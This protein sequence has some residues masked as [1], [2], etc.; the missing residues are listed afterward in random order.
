[1]SQLTRVHRRILCFFQMNLNYPGT[2]KVVILKS[3]LRI[4]SLSLH[5]F[6]FIAPHFMIL[7]TSLDYW[8]PHYVIFSIF[9]LLK[10][11]ST[12]PLKLINSNCLVQQ[13]GN[14]DFT[15]TVMD[16]HAEDLGYS[17]VEASSPT[18]PISSPYLWDSTCLPRGTI[19]FSLSKCGK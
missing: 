15:S 17:S 14:I 16:L 12:I 13:N 11:D 2:F 4:S 3:F 18:P 6:H 10:Y 7:M 1:M 9:L 8:T 19:L 5:V